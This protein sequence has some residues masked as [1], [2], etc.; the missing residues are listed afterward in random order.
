MPLI[1]TE[2]AIQSDGTWAIELYNQ[3][4]GTENL[5]DYEIFAYI[6]ITGFSTPLPSGSVAPGE[7]VSLGHSTITGADFFPS[8]TVFG[9]TPM[10]TVQLHS[11][12][13]LIDT[14]GQFNGSD[15][16]VDVVYEG[17]ITRTPN[18]DSF[19]NNLSDFTQTPGFS[20]NTL[21]A[22]CFATGTLIATLAGEVPVE[23]L[24]IGDLVS[25]AD[26]RAVPVL[27]IGSRV[28]RAGIGRQDDLSA[29]VGIDAGALGQ[30]LPHSDLTVTGDHG[31]ILDG[32]VVNAAA[33]VDH[34]TIRWVPE[35][36]AAGVTVY[37]IETEAHEVIVANG[38]ATET[39]IDY[40]GRQGFDNF[41]EYLALY[42]A[43][44]IY[45]EM[46]RPRI[47]SARMLPE[48]LRAL[49]GDDVSGALRQAG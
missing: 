12:M 44:R 6:G 16:G 42:G 20:N 19:T 40:T 22:P 15:L 28:L 46:D 45:P 17:P 39:F 3:G 36:Q 21:G 7:F 37:H 2:L 14:I 27:W 33:L 25:T 26:G 32:V 10:Q 29:L 48:A 5:S 30:G 41:A 23:A 31:M 47:T 9:L 11:S 13:N 4:P 35:A 34:R 43:E 24:R 8:D 49:L 18:T 1:I 38:A